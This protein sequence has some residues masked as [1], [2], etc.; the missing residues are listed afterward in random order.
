MIDKTLRRESYNEYKKH[1]L[2]SWF[3]SFFLVAVVT[4]LIVLSSTFSGIILIVA[5]LLI[6]PMVFAAYL[7]HL[8][9]SHDLDL[10]FGGFFK[11]FVTF[12]KNPNNGT[13]RYW[14]SVLKYLICTLILEALFCFV[15]CIVC[16][17]LDIDIFKQMIETYLEVSQTSILIENTAEV[18]GDSYNMFV[19]FNKIVTIP[20]TLISGLFIFYLLLLN[21]LS[22]Y[23][24][25]K[26]KQSNNQF[27]NLVF[28][29]ALKKDNHVIRNN[30]INL[31]WPIFILFIIGA[32]I[33][34]VVSLFLTS[35]IDFIILNGFVL[36]SLSTFFF[37]P[38][39]FANMEV[40]Y[41][42]YETHFL[43]SVSE[44][45]V[46][47]FSKFG[48]FENYEKPKEGEDNEKT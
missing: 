35:N 42:R 28:K 3:L 39:H 27:I 34:A 31:E 17:S 16:A 26:I 44:V 46:S 37:L 45:T 30:F 14:I 48:K 24:R 29:H 7:S 19:L 1:R 15:G 47:L 8:G 10:T 40:L 22:V 32:T 25:L 12:F 20:T 6:F 13:F 5:P 36:G 43:N 18:F 33:G 23:L 11:F 9:F 41:K 21:S 38:F 4:L 2:S